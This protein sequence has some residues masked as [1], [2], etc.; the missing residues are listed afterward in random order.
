MGSIRRVIGVI[1]CGLLFALL[2]PPA[3]GADG[4]IAAWGDNSQGQCNVPEPNAGFVAIAAGLDSLFFKR[5]NCESGNRSQMLSYC[6]WTQI[7]FF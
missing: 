2:A 3:T 6:N 5:G 7:F 4:S 1:A